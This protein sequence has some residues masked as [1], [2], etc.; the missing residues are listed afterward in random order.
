MNYK[1]VHARVGVL[2]H[3]KS[4]AYISPV[5]KVL[6]KIFQRNFKFILS[7]ILDETDHIPQGKTHNEN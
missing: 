7:I 6:S 4:L 5:P 3:L 1:C 2:M